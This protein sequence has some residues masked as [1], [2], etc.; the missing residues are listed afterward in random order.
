MFLF[1]TQQRRGQVLESLLIALSFTGPLESKHIKSIITGFV[2]NERFYLSNQKT[3]GY[4]KKQ[5]DLF[6]PT[7]RATR[8]VRS[9]AIEL[10]T[11][12]VGGDKKLKHEVLLVRSLF[13][14]L[15]HLELK[16]IKRIAKQKRSFSGYIP[17]LTIEAQTFTLLLEVDT[18]TQS[19]SSIQTKIK[20]YHFRHQQGTLIYFTT[21]LKTYLHFQCNYFAQFIYLDSPTLEQDLKGIKVR[22]RKMCATDTIALF[23][24]KEESLI[25]DN[26][27]DFDLETMRLQVIRLLEADG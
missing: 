22:H 14:C 20:N 15:L 27:T 3:R 10:V 9:S 16:H 11:N 19:I 5:E 2:Q 13:V 8:L 18:G 7:S 24:K 21:S 1:Q 25:S 17:D 26:R 12:R 23:S 6:K 4:L